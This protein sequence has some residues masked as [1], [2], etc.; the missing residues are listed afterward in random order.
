MKKIMIIFFILICFGC[1]P[2]YGYM[3]DPEYYSYDNPR[4]LYSDTIHYSC[5]QKRIVHYYEE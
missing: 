3:A 1:S 4:I 2:H 5:G